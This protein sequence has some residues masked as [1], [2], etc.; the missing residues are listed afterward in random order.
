MVRAGKRSG[1]D[2]P[3]FLLCEIPPGVGGC[4][5][6][7]RVFG[8]GKV[9]ARKFASAS[10]DDFA[11][12]GQPLVPV[13]AL[14][15][16]PAAGQGAG[17][18]VVGFLLERVERLADGQVSGR[19]PLDFPAEGVDFFQEHRVFF[20]QRRDRLDRLLGGLDPGPHRALARRIAGRGGQYHRRGHFVA[21]LRAAWTSLAALAMVWTF[22][23]H[24]STAKYSAKGIGAVH[25]DLQLA[26]LADPTAKRS[27]SSHTAPPDRPW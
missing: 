13:A 20:R 25:R 21:M 6:S 8:R 9:D 11:S 2:R 17:I 16:R 22:K 18:R 5:L 15:A 10:S 14:E 12:I 3:L 7:L 24:G 4:Q 26:R 23:S 27:T 19:L 1:L